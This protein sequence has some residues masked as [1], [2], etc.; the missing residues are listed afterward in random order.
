MSEG[1]DEADLRRELADVRQALATVTGSLRY[2]IGDA[3]VT[4]FSGKASFGRRLSILAA[5]ARRMM[6]LRQAAAIKARLFSGLPGYGLPADGGDAS[7]ARLRAARRYIEGLE[8]GRPVSFDFGGAE[9]WAAAAA[10]LALEFRQAIDNGFPLDGLAPNSSHIGDRQRIVY[11]SQHDPT[12][13]SNGYAR[14]TREIVHRLA[15]MG[16]S[17]LVVI[18]RF[19]QGPDAQDDFSDGLV[20]YRRLCLGSP[21]G[22]GFSGYV[23]ALAAA[24]GEAAKAHR[25]GIVHAASNYLNGLAA[26]AA[27]R[28][29]SIPCLYEV[30]GLWEETRIS[31]DPAFSSTLGYRLQARMEVFCVGAADA[32]VA[33]SIGIADELRRRGAAADFA[34]AE[35]GAPETMPIDTEIAASFRALFPAQSRV[36]GFV[37]SIT[38]YEGFPTIAAALAK[39]VAEDGRYRMLIVGDGRYMGEA[40]AAFMRTG[41]ADHVVFAGR[42]PLAEA[43]SAY[44]AIDLALYPR[45]STRVTEIVESL[46]PVEALAAGVAVVVSNVAPLRQLAENCPG[47][48]TV[49]ASDPDDLTRAVRQFFASSSAERRATGEAGREWVIAHRSWNHTA[50]TIAESYLRI[51]PAS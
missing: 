39:L 12:T 26:L 3:V 50:R 37:G 42:R 32:A 10:R 30:R 47:V 19:Q 41:M 20:S 34:I 25:A 2:Q 45:D 33:G 28:S 24:I 9:D 7:V 17:I 29:L 13:T 44:G 48:L 5:A 36:L 49:K 31:I 23:N 18:P 16:F 22:P 4:A 14:R 8:R 1:G 46:K 43:V 35:S 6:R 21:P 11:V 15:Q 38:A 40:K 51:A 27:A